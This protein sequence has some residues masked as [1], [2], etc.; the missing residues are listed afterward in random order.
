MEIVPDTPASK[1]YDQGLEKARERFCHRSSEEI[2][3]TWQAIPGF[4]LGP[5][6]L[7]DDDLRRLSGRQLHRCGDVRRALFE[8][9]SQLQRRGLCHL[10][11]GERILSSRFLISRATRTPPQKSLTAFQGLV[12]KYPKSEYVEDSKYKLQVIRGSA[13]RQGNVD[14]PVLSEPPQLHGGD[15]PIP[16]RVAKLS[17]DPACRRSALSSGRSLSGTWESPMRRKRPRRCWG[18]IFPNSQW[19]QDAYALLKGKGLSPQENSRVLDGEDLSHGRSVLT[20]ACAML[21]RLSIRDVV[22]IDQL[23][24]E[25]S[26]GLNNPHWR[27]GR[28]QIHPSGCAF[29]G[30]WRAWG[31]RTCPPRRNAGP[32][33]RGVRIAARTCGPRAGSRGRSIEIGDELILRRVQLADGRTRAYIN[34]QSVS[35]QALRSLASALVEIH[36]QHDERALTD[37]ATHRALVNSYAGADSL[38]VATQQCFR[39]L[40]QP[41]TQARGRARACRRGGGGRRFRPARSRRN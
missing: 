33:D 11:A 14:R 18:T 25:F 32:G 1:T 17:N 12:Q 4:R 24:V 7:A 2:H 10:F 13:R 20:G 5:E 39:R 29:A 35:A 6:G 15:Q 22:L 8:G 30:A 26:A 16:Q 36:G 37:P 38:A 41:G 21:A 28:R 19:Y 34:D 23:D 9:I 31:W 40:A 27:D 3:R